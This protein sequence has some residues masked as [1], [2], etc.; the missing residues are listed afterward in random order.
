MY[1]LKEVNRKTTQT[2]I[3]IVL[4]YDLKQLKYFVEIKNTRVEITDSQ[5]LKINRDFDWHEPE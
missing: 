1:T 5:F 2:A 3:P 4:E